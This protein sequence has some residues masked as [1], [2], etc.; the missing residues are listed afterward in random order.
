MSGSNRMFGIS[1]FVLYDINKLYKQQITAQQFLLG[2]IL[3]TIATFG[4]IY[5]AIMN[6]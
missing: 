4:L 5:N 3:L 6:R 2:L 1:F